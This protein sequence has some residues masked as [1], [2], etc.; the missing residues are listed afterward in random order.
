MDP[1]PEQD[2]ADLELATRELEQAGLGFVIVKAQ[3]VVASSRAHGIGSLLAAAE[4]L[5]R[6]GQPAASLAD[7]I[8]GQAALMVACWA[9][10]RALHAGLISEAAL[11]EA[12]RR[13]LPVSFRYRV[14][15]ILNRHRDGPCPF[16]QAASQAIDQGL[17]LDEIILRLR[18]VLKTMSH[19]PVD[20]RPPA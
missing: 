18:E 17:A 4:H 6:D 5:R 2:A 12:R 7:R 19:A 8:V 11:K 14:P 9:D 16:E 1:I 15:G 20:E 10:I 3:R 13:A